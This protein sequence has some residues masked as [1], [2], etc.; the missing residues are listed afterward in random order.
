MTA[1]KAPVTPTRTTWRPWPYRRDASSQ[2]RAP[3]RERPPRAAR[4]WSRRGADYIAEAARS[5]S[6]GRSRAP[7]RGRNRRWRGWRAVTWTAWSQGRW[8]VEAAG[9]GVCRLKTR[10]AGG[11]GGS[12]PPG[13][14]ALKNF[15]CAAE[16]RCRRS[17]RAPSKALGSWDPSAS[18][19]PGM[20]D[21]HPLVAW[22]SG[23]RRRALPSWT[24]PHA[25]G[26]G[27]HWGSTSA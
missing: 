10:W 18:P 15:C 7:V 13:E 24:S 16:E 12:L 23:L 14:V 9:A 17:G 19:T 25:R 4:W 20:A 11:R 21:S 3:G 8:S 27:E 2:F 22:W 1:L 5:T 26:R 6:R